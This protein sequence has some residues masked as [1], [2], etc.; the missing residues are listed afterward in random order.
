MNNSLRRDKS[1]IQTIELLN[2]QTLGLLCWE[3]NLFIFIII[4]TL[5]FLNGNFF[6]ICFIK[7]VHGRWHKK[8]KGEE[9]E[10]N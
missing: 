3:H 4:F 7:Q 10:Q 1:I 2:F 5:N 8:A 6:V 9:H